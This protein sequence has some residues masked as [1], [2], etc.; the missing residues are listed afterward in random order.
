MA[1]Q[2]QSLR[3]VIVHIGPH[4]TGSTAIQQCLTANSAALQ[5]AGIAFLHGS[6]IHEIAMLLVR[7]SFDEAEARFRLLS[8]QISTTNAETIILSQEDFCGDLP[9]RSRQKAI[10][11]KLT[12]NLRIIARGLQPHLVIFVFFEREASQW[13]TSCYHQHLRYRTLFSRFEDFEAHFGAAPDWRE[14]LEK[15]RETFGE[16]FITV[17][18]SKVADAGVAALLHIAGQASVHLS[19]PPKL[20]NASPQASQIRSLERINALSSFKATAWFA[21]ALVLENWS[22]RPVIDRR[23]LQPKATEIPAKIA[24][25]ELVRRAQRRITRQQVEDILPPR[26]QNLHDLLFDVLPLDI[27][28][29]AVSRVDIRNQSRLLDYHLRGKSQLAKLNGLT[30]SYLRRDTDHTDKA[31]HLFHRIWAE[32]GVLLVNELSTR[33]LIST[34]QTFLDHGANEAQRMIGASG[35]F[36]ANMMK[37][38]EGERAIEG[39]EQDAIYREVSPQTQNKFS[40]LDRYDVGS[41]DLL[42]NTNALALDLAMRDDVAGLVLQEFLLR[43]KSSANV[44]TRMD[45]SRKEGNIEVKGFEDTWSFFAPR[46]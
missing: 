38:Y 37:I 44:F 13:L 2:A 36:Y 10:Y 18:H 24:L 29:P 41:T 26:D 19:E 32:E 12:K 15:P 9:G 33:W 6:M 30:I 22:P 3:R 43:V 31:R 8:G 25:P 14:K 21:K 23:D 34:L 11:P 20:S 46:N 4:K 45:T 17:T 35:Y 27:E 42:L 1:E 5:A 39:L 16:Q 40:G 7:Q 28:L